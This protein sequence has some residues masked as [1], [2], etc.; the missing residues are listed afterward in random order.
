[1]KTNDAG[2]IMDEISSLLGK[3]T[4]EDV[5]KLKLLMSLMPAAQPVIEEKDAVTLR[6]FVEEYK[7]FIQQNRSK[8]YFTSVTISFDHLIN[9]F[10]PQRPI[11]TIAL[12]DIET[13][14]PAFSKK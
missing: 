5:Q 13:F 11:G 10:K 8:N 3:L 6:L 1:M 2:K 7:T 9:Y 4:Y 12:K 14:V